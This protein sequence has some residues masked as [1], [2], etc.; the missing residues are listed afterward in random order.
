MSSGFLPHRETQETVVTPRE[1]ELLLRAP[2]VCRRQSV[3]K[4][5]GGFSVNYSVPEGGSVYGFTKVM[6][7]C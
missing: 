4:A 3:R 2:A 1:R 7:C 5:A 6:S